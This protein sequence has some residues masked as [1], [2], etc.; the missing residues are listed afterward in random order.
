MLELLK[1]IKPDRQELETW[2]LSVNGTCKTI[3]ILATSGKF[4]DP[5]PR[6][7]SCLEQMVSANVPVVW[8]IFPFK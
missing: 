8:V 2:I 7:N 1:I 4:P 3:I 6:M 5:R